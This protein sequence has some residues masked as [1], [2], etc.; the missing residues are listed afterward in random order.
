MIGAWGGVLGGGGRHTQ[1]GFN[2]GGGTQC[3][4]TGALGQMGCTVKGIELENVK[5]DLYGY[6]TPPSQ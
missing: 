3:D 1:G 2:G 4:E 5:A 6:T